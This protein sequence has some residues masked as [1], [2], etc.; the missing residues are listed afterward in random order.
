[1]IVGAER[2]FRW[3]F[4]P[5]QSFTAGHNSMCGDCVEGLASRARAS[6]L[7]TV[8]CGGRGFPFFLWRLGCLCSPGGGLLKKEIRV[9][10]KHYHSTAHVWPLP[11][12]LP[13]IFTRLIPFCFM[14]FGVTR[15]SAN[16]QRSGIH[17]LANFSPGFLTRKHILQ[18]LSISVF[19]A[20][21]RLCC[22]QQLSKDYADFSPSSA[23]SKAPSFSHFLCILEDLECPDLKIT[24]RAQPKL[25]SGVNPRENKPSCTKQML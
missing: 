9:K 2:G 24:R 11:P 17:I 1:M 5:C 4:E 22:S 23:S 20:S 7:W 19:L 15:W 8:V 6:P 13:F 14:Y 21:F 10:G 18:F 25:L 16:R 3:R 12:P